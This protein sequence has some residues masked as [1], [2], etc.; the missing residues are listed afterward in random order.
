MLSYTDV[1]PAS[2]G[3]R[4]A[5]CTLGNGYLAT[6]GAAP[7]SHA[8]G[9][10]Y[11]GVYLAG[12]YD[13]LVSVV[14]GLPVVNED[15]VNLPNWLCLK[16]RV[17]DGEWFG[18]PDATASGYRQQLDLRTGALTR[19]WVYADSLGRRTRVSQRRAVSMA[20]RHLALLE[21]TLRPLNWSGCV[22]VQT[23]VDGD[24]VNDNVMEYRALANRHWLPVTATAPGDTTS[25]VADT[26]TSRIRV[27]VSAR[28]SVRDSAAL[29]RT[30]PVREG[31]FYAA[32]D[33]HLVVEQGRDVVIDKVAAV[34]SSR[35]RPL[36]D[37]E[38]A[39]R[40]TL[41]RSTDM[42]ALFTDH[43]RAWA[44]LWSRFGVE[45]RTT[46]GIALAIN[47]HLFHLLQALSPHTIDIDAGVPARGLH[48]EGYRGHVFW[49]E[50]F[51]TPL[52]GLRLPAL[53]RSLLEYRCRRLDAARV[54]AAEAGYRGAMFPWQS[55]GSGEEETPTRLFNVRSRRWMPDNSRL[56]RH[57]GIAVAYEIWQHYE[58]TGDDLWLADHGAE[59]MLEIARFLA[60]L[61]S[62]DAEHDRYG[63]HGVM[64]P[65]EFHDGYPD[66]PTPGLRNNAYTNVMTVWV[67][68]RARALLD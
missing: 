55:A 19:T 54:A 7:E 41:R 25:V 14:D 56:Q 58:V 31:A 22:V 23:G 63:I 21:T 16:I 26:A 51:V 32:L 12:V 42:D 38:Q 47:L 43:D 4:E 36:V 20:D 11:P 13:R 3:T 9:V 40:G 68:L 24:V 64:G 49:D 6:R 61:T 53:A 57:V 39:A 50:V 33:L 10:H 52:L 18:P 34:H 67:L 30:D 46:P 62:Y 5:L 37:P 48:G 35:D 66:A 15:M 28:T 1:D 65:D 8:D 2:V 59:T 44:R 17:G 60:D 27:A 29:T 45:A